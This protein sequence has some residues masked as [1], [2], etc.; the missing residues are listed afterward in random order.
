MTKSSPWASVVIPAHNEER[1]I[2][3]CLEVLQ[4]GLRPGEL[5]VVVVANGCT[6]NT[7]RVARSAVPAVR[8]VSLAEASKAA[9]LNAG[10]AV[11]SAFPR[12]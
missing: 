10:D 5:E 3:R 12:A 6:D 7:E 8:V 9:A 4:A 2:G 11:A 1:V